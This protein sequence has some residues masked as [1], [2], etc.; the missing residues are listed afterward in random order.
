[1]ATI[2]DTMRDGIA[3]ATGTAVEVPGLVTKKTVAR[4]LS[5]SC[6]TVE[7][8]M[9]GRRIPCVRLGKRC[10][11]FD[12]PAVLVALRKFEIREVQ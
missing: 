2:K 3:P 8:W 9:R 5:V 11:R 1:M 12:L 4:A 7:T 6:R 10:V